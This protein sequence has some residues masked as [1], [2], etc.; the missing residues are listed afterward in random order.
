MHLTALVESRDHVCCRYR[1]AAFRPFFAQAGH[2]LELRPL[3]PNWWSRLQAFAA[4]RQTEV[5]ILQRKL[6]PL[7]QLGWLRRA[8]RLLIFDFDDAV[9]LRDS[10]SA[11]GLHSAT[12][13]RRFGATVRA[14]DAV[15]AAL[16][17]KKVQPI[18]TPVYGCP[19]YD[20]VSESRRSQT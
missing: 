7:W 1:L 8:A 13:L 14:A 2:T 3:P 20:S 19:L 16:N 6:L 10:Y 9:F 15:I 4:P 5:V 17:G 18:T 12:R 11:K